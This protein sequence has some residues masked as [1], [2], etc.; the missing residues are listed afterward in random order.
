VPVTLAIELAIFAVGVLL[1]LRETTARDRIGSIGLWALVI[2]L[3]VVYLGNVFG[4][5]P[6]NAAAVAWSAQA[7]WLLVAWGHWVDKHRIPHR[8]GGQRLGRRG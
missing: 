1:Y 6:P 5:P 2:F 8:N 7:M 4:P 3:L